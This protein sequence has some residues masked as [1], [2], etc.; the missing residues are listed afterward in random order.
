MD[1]KLICGCTQCIWFHESGFL[2]GVHASSTTL[3]FAG[4]LYQLS[5]H[6]FGFSLGSNKALA[7]QSECHSDSLYQIMG[8]FGF[9]PTTDII[10]CCG[11]VVTPV[12]IFIKLI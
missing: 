5:L 7:M 11:L 2:S 10:S 8:A 4:I 12:G 6:L 3:V 9:V 1:Q